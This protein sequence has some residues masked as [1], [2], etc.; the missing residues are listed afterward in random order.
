[1]TYI[2]TLTKQPNEDRLYEMQ[3]VGLLAAGETITG[4][5]SVTATPAGLTLSG[6]PTYEGSIAKQRISGGTNGTTYKVTFVVTTSDGNVLE[7]EGKLKVR[8]L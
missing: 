4:V 3:F 7:G 6:A 5:T 2:P 8:D 1:V